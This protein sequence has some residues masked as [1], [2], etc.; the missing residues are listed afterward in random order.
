MSEF[1]WPHL[2]IS[3]YLIS[4]TC[5]TRLMGE[6]YVLYTDENDTSLQEADGQMEGFGKNPYWVTENEH[7]SCRGWPKNKPVWN[8][9]YTK[10]CINMVPRQ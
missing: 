6:G 4:V 8:T 7:V 5:S 1:P 2:L 10:Y 9:L 3:V